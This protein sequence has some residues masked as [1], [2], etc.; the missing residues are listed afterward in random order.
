M[1][2]KNKININKFWGRS[3]KAQIHVEMIVSFVIFVGFL[4]V[5]MFYINP[6]G[7]ETI[8]YS[9]IDRIQE[10]IISN[11]SSNYQETSVIFSDD[12]TDGPGGSSQ[13]CLK[14]SDYP[15]DYEKTRAF[16]YGGDGVKSEIKDKP[17]KKDFRLGVV[18]DKKA[19]MVYASDDFSEDAPTG[20]CP[21]AHSGADYE[22]GIIFS[23]RAVFYDKLSE[24]N[25]RYLDDYG[26]MKSDL[27]IEKDFEFIVYDETRD[28]LFNESLGVHELKAN[29]VISRDIPLVM[30]YSNASQSKIILNI[31]VW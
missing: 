17:Q 4:L 3:R 24:F 11:I 15:L 26:G 27:G 1:G 14:F 18:S 19:Y 5:L 20:N 21:D 2:I 30:M 12:P 8:S 7:E 31:R 25:N 16:V 23:S 22:W 10:K 9:S 29:T 13:D 28:V 6:I